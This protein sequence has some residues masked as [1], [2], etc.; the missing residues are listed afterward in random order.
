MNRFPTVVALALMC[1]GIAIPASACSMAGCLNHG[2]EMRQDFVVTIKH[3]GKP[4]A[5]VAVQISGNEKQF[6]LPTSTD[7]RVHVT[8]LPPGDYWLDAQLLGISAAYQCFH[9]ADRPTREAKRKLTY[10]WGDEAPAT[11]RIAGKLIDS[12]PG[13]GGTPLWNLVHRT[14]VPI[15]GASLKLRSPTTGAVYSTTSGHDGRF[16]FDTIPAG[17]YVLHVEGGSAGERGYDA[18]D[19]LIELSPQGSRSL[20]LLKRRDAGGGSCGGTSLELQ[21]V[22]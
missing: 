11:Q 14:D 9:V 3:G 22:N 8:D 13:K 15:V 7:G 17:T 21:D 12:Q 19:Q 1:Y 16:G 4:L 2:V 18:T 5:G 10:E 6:T 20:I